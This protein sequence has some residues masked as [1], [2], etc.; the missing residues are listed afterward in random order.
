MR[1]WGA[2]PINKRVI[3]N[4]DDDSAIE[5]VLLKRTGALLVLADARYHTKG[6]D[7]VPMDGKAYVERQRV[8]FVQEP[9]GD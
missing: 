3:A 2:Y 1:R 8:L 4:L 5:G 7:P 9:R 6:A